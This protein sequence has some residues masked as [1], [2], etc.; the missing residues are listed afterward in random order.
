MPQDDTPATAAL[1]WLLGHRPEFTND[2][3][4]GRFS[5]TFLDR[6]SV[7]QVKQVLRDVLPVLRDKTP[8]L[9]HPGAFAL[10]AELGHYE[11]DIWVSDT[12]PHLIEGLTLSSSAA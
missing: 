6:V 2:D 4:R 7:A 9:K 8:V 1:H 3:I 10:T 12:T 11:V 5:T